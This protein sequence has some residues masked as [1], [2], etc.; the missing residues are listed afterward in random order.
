MLY[1][2]IGAAVAVG[3]LIGLTALSVSRIAARVSKNIRERSVYLL[4]FYDEL[5]KEK[6]GELQKLK[7][8]D[9]SAVPE[10]KERSKLPEKTAVS[11]ASSK[12]VMKTLDKITNS[13]YLDSS[14]AD[15]YKQIRAGFTRDISQTL[16]SLN[17]PVSGRGNG[18]ATT[19]LK[20][21]SYD[22]VYS[23]S[24]LPGETQLEVMTEALTGK[25][26]KLLEEYLR[27]NRSF[28]CI[29]F[30][31]WLKA[32]SASEPSKIKLYVT[33]ADAQKRYPDY[34]E[35]IVDRDIC[36]GF[37][38]EADNTVYDYCIKGKE[39]S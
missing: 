29:E 15:A 23:L 8:A 34:V 4:S 28:D 12:D 18:P 30:Y 5:L 25:D 3:I 35:V 14:A 33:E 22:T 39:I 16:A 7:E 1:A 9:G 6:S 21:F 24:V 31:D 13:E 10:T 27:D 32:R 17:I 26:R 11:S 20:Q 2:Y 38:I 36:E 19:L 37:M